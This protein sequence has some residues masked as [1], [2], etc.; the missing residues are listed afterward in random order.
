MLP[1]VVE[2]TNVNLDL[3]L[4]DRTG[5]A[6]LALDGWR[7]RAAHELGPGLKEARPGAPG[8]RR[9]FHDWQFL[10]NGTALAKFVGCGVFSCA[11]I[12]RFYRQFVP[13]CSEWGFGRSEGV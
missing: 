7:V 2:S 3:G 10:L 12:C 1:L 6:P 9:L 11:W 8:T 4:S 5:L 13:C